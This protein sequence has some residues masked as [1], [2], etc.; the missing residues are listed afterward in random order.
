[1]SDAL[2]APEAELSR[3]NL[4]FDRLA[5]HAYML[6]FTLLNG[7]ERH[8]TSPL[9]LSFIAAEDRIAA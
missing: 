5:L 2:Y 1:V 4:G 7:E 3:D 9:P 8:F 6:A